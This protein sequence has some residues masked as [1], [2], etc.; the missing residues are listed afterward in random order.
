M[1]T[2]DFPFSLWSLRVD[3][4]GG[5]GSLTPGASYLPDAPLVTGTWFSVT[6]HND[7][8]MIKFLATYKQK[9]Y[10][11]LSDNFDL[12]TYKANTRKP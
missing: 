8:L 7:L 3:Q 6:F 4:S 12:K 9:S 10:L 2:C 1:H 5:G 11:F